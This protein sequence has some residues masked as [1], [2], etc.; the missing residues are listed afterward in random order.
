MRTFVR[1]L[2]RR[3]IALTGT[4]VVLLILVLALFSPFIATHDPMRLNP[5]V[6]LQGPSAAH[7]FGTDHFGRDIFSRVVYGARLTLI[8][9]MGV[10]FY[11][12]VGGVAIGVLSGYFR[13]FGFVAM[14]L[15]DV[16][17]SFPAL[18]LALA[19]LAI[20]GPGLAN[21]IIAVGINFLTRTARIIFGLT[22]KLKEEV[23]VEAIRSIGAGSARILLRHI[24]PNLMSPLIVQA[25]FTF[26]FSLLQI[27]SL[28]FLG[29]GVPP[30]IPSWGNMIS[31]GR[32]YI[33][34][35]PGV[36]LFPGIFIVLTVLAFNLV[37]DVLRDNLDPRFR[38]QLGGR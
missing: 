37:G 33:T 5:A 17:M 7:W 24:L 28:D 19:L 9:G 11:S 36:L 15:V 21:V 26:A 20:L 38:D 6:R 30:Q 29:V 27:A 8:G 35:A 32:I 18:L 25:T 4:G 2:V 10:V 13:R 34:R 3:K 1:S 14:R 12:V 23:F 16:V 22:L 31:E